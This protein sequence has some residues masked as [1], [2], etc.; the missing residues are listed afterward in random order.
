MRFALGR[1]ETPADQCSLSKLRD[2]FDASGHDVKKL[3]VS[4]VLSDAFRSKRVLEET[5]P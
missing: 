1:V 3:L 4:V 5:A 2:A